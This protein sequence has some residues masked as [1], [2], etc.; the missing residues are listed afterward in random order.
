MKFRALV[1]IY[2]ML[3][4]NVMLFG[5]EYYVALNGNDSNPGSLEQPFASIQHAVTLLKAGDVCYVRGGRY[6]EAIQIDDLNGREGQPITIRSYENEKVILDGSVPINTKWIRHKGQIFKTTLDQDIWQ[7]FVNDET[8]ISARW[9]NAS[10][11][12]G[13]IWDMEK[14]WGH[15]YEEST[16]G[17]FINDPVFQDLA[18]T[19]IDFT[20]AIVMM[21]IGAWITYATKVISHGKGSDSFTYARN[22]WDRLENEVYWEHR[23]LETGWYFFE[24]SLDMLDTVGEWS[25]QT[26]SGKLYFWPYEN[27]FPE[28]L[29]IR[30][31]TLSYALQIKNSGYVKI[32]GLDFFASTFMIDN[33]HHV[34][35][36]DGNFKYPSYSRR[37]LGITDR[38]DVTLING[39]S[40]NT[41]RN[42]T[43]SY[44]DGE[45]L[46]VIGEKHLIENCYFHEINYSCIG[47]AVT[48]DLGEAVGTTFRRNT[49][50]TGGASVGLRVG[51]ENIVEYNN[52][53]D[54]GHL[55]TDGALIQMS[56]H[57]QTGTV[58]RYN[59]LHESAKANRFDDDPKFGIRFDGSFTGYLVGERDLPHSGTVHH[60]V[61][62]DTRGVFVKGDSHQVYNNLSFDNLRND[63]AIRSGAGQGNPK[64]P[65]KGYNYP[66]W[67]PGLYHPDEND[68]STIR[69]NLAGEI[70]SNLATLS[71]GL[72][73]KNSNNWSGDVRIPLRDPDRLDF[74]QAPSSKLIDAGYYI[75]GITDNYVGK[76]PDIGP[77]E[78]GAE[79]Y[80]IPGNKSKQASTP[81]PPDGAMGVR[82]DSD[83]KWLEGYRATGHEVYFGTNW[84]AVY[85]A[86][87]NSP[88]YKG[89]VK[90]NIL[91][92]DKSELELRKTYYWR[93]DVLLESGM[94]I[95]GKVWSF[96]VSRKNLPVVFT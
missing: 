35:V 25:Y 49:M 86:D 37:M 51:P 75:E 19:G 88:E 71:N 45:G 16:Y 20:N 58:I 87:P 22:L 24:G 74:R 65:L 57:A 77:Y 84:K 60:N 92:L 81:I 63:L 70:S 72:P 21:N 39:G 47:S 82:A 8:M 90:H 3:V 62:W 33:S 28:G 43:F 5:K 54:I 61:I 30:G 14:T 64:D 32:K 48:V 68:H 73:G 31:K 83:L 40:Q 26:D 67:G 91:R 85:N 18:A 69:N 15:Q 46:E 59:W 7:L 66:G 76:A 95:R 4:T 17:H 41:V 89:R 29:E 1:C 36:E 80:W 23:A 55:Q 6:H 9:P 11:K 52:I 78:T 94:K 96:T 42:C 38:P 56:G 79:H 12:D 34:I 27:N 2:V 93:V 13:S 53:Y 44:S 10:W 50:H